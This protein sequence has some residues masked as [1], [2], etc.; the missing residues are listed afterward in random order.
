M[1]YLKTSYLPVLSIASAL[2]LSACG[3]GGGGG[4]TTTPVTPP[5]PVVDSTAPTLTFN[6]ATLTV[7]SEATGSSTFTATDA[8]GVTVGP[9][10]TCT[11]GGQ[12]NITTNV[13]TAPAVTA[14]TSS[15]CTA[16][17]SDAAGNEGTATLT[18]SI[19]AP[20][21]DTEAPV[22]TFSPVALTVESGRTGA[23]TLTATDNTGVTTG[24][25][26]VCTNGGNFDVATNT[27]TAATVTNET[28]SVCTAS[29]SDEAGNEGSDTLTVTMTPPVPD[30]TAPVVS[31]DPATLTVQAG[32][33]VASTLTATDDTAVTTGPT[34]ICTNGGSF[35]VA[36]NLF[37]A[38]AVTA[39]TESICTATAG[40]EAGNEGTGILTVTMTPA[41]VAQTV[42]LSGTLTYDRVPVSSTSNG[43]DYNNIV[44]MPIRQAPVDLLDPAGTVLD[45]TVSDA[46]GNYSFDVLSL[47]DVRV[48]VRSEV[49]MA[50]PN[51]VDMQVV[52][53]TAGDA[54][55]AIQGA[56]SEVPS[57]N[58]IRNLN[59]DSGWGGSSYVTA[60]AAA[61]FALLDTIYEAL[62]D[63]I[64]VDPE[65]DFPA[66]DVQWS[67][68][69][70][71][72]GGNVDIG[73]IG[74]SSFTT[75]NRGS[76]AAPNLVPVL[77]I[78]GAEDNDTDEYDV[79]VVVHEFGHYFEN[80]ISRADSIGGPHSS[81]DRLDARVAFG[82]GWGNALSGMILDD[83]VYRDSSTAR[84]SR[85][86]SIDVE[87]NTYASTGW[88]SEGSVQSILYDLFDDNNAGDGADS[89]SFG[90]GPIY[91]AFTDPAYESTEAFTTIF[92]FLEALDNQAGVSSAA[93]TALTN[94]QD[95]SGSTGFGV[96]ETNDGG[97]PDA[98]PVYET[99]LTNGTPV[100]FCS[101]DNFGNFNKH[102][103]RRYFR[104]DIP[105]A[106]AYRF[107]MNQTT[108]GSGDPD[109][110][111]FRSGTLV[112]IGGSGDNRTEVQD[113]N[114]PAGTHVME[115]YAFRNI[116]QGATTGDICYTFT[117]EAR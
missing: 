4:T 73:Q 17:A 80:S 116:Q 48:R 90:L 16:T 94:A 78:L 12:F 54:V 11:N 115:A 84:Q 38:A 87:N 28:I 23:S 9:N 40:D 5:P 24:P 82:E 39:E 74:T 6:P 57:T 85:G 2:L 93:I 21:P 66:F 113:I 56:L 50:A 75:E 111:V 101:V 35:D 89:A 97:L 105:S 65:V 99:L 41:P 106:G 18:V 26:V 25:T 86:F 64:A 42:T 1:T 31:F 55:Y 91:G 95:I 92:A 103:V 104:I 13:F 102:G 88:Y 77:R 69:N 70:R 62:E 14:D 27:F 20:V 110:L 100:D 79:H 34:V 67:P 96:G 44:Q 15:V 32:L 83:P 60:R 108:A 37:T 7:E 59:A 46:N 114:L 61:P 43:L 63:F 33:T 30:T 52:D 51:E 53:N 45:S 98:L 117:V 19:T 47:Q 107:S 29:A 58:Q 10:V 49:Q 72:E 36:A 109:F 76:A 3:G 22:V 8:V 81:N 71:P 112:A 68:L